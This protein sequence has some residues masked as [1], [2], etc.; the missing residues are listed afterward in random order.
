MTDLSPRSAQRDSGYFR[1]LLR[2]FPED[3]RDEMGDS[4][5]EAYRDRVRAAGER[6]GTI[7]VAFI[8]V[9]AFFDSLLNGI[10]ERLRPSVMWRRSGNWGRDTELAVRRIRRSPL[11]TLSIIA[12]LTI[13]LG[14]FAVT[15]AVVNKVLLAPLPYKHPDDLYFAWRDYRKFF[16]LE[17][18]WLGGPDITILAK[19]G[20]VIEDAAGMIRDSR[21]LT[22]D[23][24][25]AEPMMIDIMRTTPN[26]FP[27]LGVA[28]MLGRGFAAEEI[29]PQRPAVMVLTYSLWQRLGGRE[30]I[31]GTQ[32]RLSA[33][34]YTVI[35]V[36]PRNFT[37]SRRASLGGP[38]AADAYIPL[39]A[40][41]AEANPNAGSYT[42]LVRAK[43][44]ATPEQV[45]AAIVQA[46][47]ALDRKHF[48]GR[49]M[50]LFGVGFKE[51]LI[52][53]LRPALLVL[54]AAGIVLVLV[55]MVNLSTLLLS[56]AA[57]RE[58][59]FAVSRALGASSSAVARATLMEGALLGT[60]G[61]MTAALAAVWATKALASMAP[62]DI[63]RRE[64]IAM[65]WP[66]AALVVGVGA[67]M[68]FLAAVAPAAW[69]TRSSLGSLLAN[70]NVRGGGGHGTM[71]RT[72][73]VLQ[74]AL[75]LVLLSA[76]GL[77]V[78]SFARL[79]Q[80]Q[81]GFRAEGVLTMFVPIP[82]ARIADT[83]DVLSIQ[84]RMV[85]SL[86][87]IPG[88]ESVSSTDALP[89]S[90]GANQMGLR[91]PGAPGNNGNEDH[92]RPLVDYMAVLPG[93]F[94][95]MGIKMLAGR[96]FSSLRTGRVHEVVIDKAMADYFFPNANALGARIPF[97]PPD[98]VTVVGIVQ[99]PR[100]YDMSKDDRPQIYYRADD[101]ISGS[102]SMFYVLRT[103]GD[104][105]RLT[106]DVRRAIREVD[107]QLAVADIMTM[108]EL[109]SRSVSR[110]RVT[111]I[112]I[113]G[114]ALGGLLLAAMGLFGVVAGN[115]TRRQH[116]L[117]VRIA[118]GA[119]HGKVL[120]RIILEGTSLVLIGLVIAAPV[121]YW[122]GK[123]M[124]GILGGVGPHDVPTLLAVAAILGAVALLACYLPAR[125]VL[126][127][128]PA[129]ALR[130]E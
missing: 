119:Q 63:P 81:P 77:V 65:D 5:V 51:D 43:H 104:P 125:R 35:G 98:T 50:K 66:T 18:G 49:G 92:D 37:F 53:P 112:L 2:F 52:G 21:T 56:R 71:R 129:E 117:A 126:Q 57:R 36:L 33:T 103:K 116:E 105:G 75:S 78:R 16:D 28:P 61:G 110:Q 95:T 31:V 19:S 6:G 20:G 48:R 106:N 30:D 46:G 15:S 59:E 100:L 94:A 44:G 83:L 4:F 34:P 68:G 55:L 99:Q 72:M 87:A 74:V 39:D 67:V 124:A 70:T 90:A 86:Q 60:L 85:A 123:A 128:D 54:A 8:Y 40:I 69:A 58:K 29:G 93:Y 89:L 11:F 120:R 42:G 14:A 97:G 101:N 3:F 96:D 122:A 79:L 7:S 114:F 108:E 88:V 130:E 107:P 76:G 38:E 111:A 80:S 41:P 32:V 127:I 9:R 13:G 24:A 62:A 23:A 12:T 25:G 45:K 17:R 118:L 47:V 84:N 113:G 91:I 26:F 102:R 121:V 115:V 64:F 22:T 27:L 1:G 73:V 109:S 10:A 82:E